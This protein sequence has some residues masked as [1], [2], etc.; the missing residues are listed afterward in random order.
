MSTIKL[1]HTADVHLDAPNGSLGPRAA[2]LRERTWSAWD[3]A[4]DQALE[5]GI[6][7][8]IVAGDL[9]DV[10][11]PA[12]RTVERALSGI[13]RLAEATPA[14]E[15]VLLPGTHDCWA[16]GALWDSPR[17]K[18]LA[19][20]VHLLRGPEAESVHIPHLDVMVHGC[21]HRCDIRGQRPVCE[22]R[23]SSE[24]TINIG[25]AH[26]SWERGDI[27]EDS[28]MYSDAE[29]A[30]TGLDY[31]ALGH[32]H[33]FFDVS[34]GGVTA[35]N[36]GSPEVPGFGNWDRGSVAVVTLG[37]GPAL[38]QRV[39]V[40]SLISETVEVDAA[41]LSGTE[42]LISRLE[43]HADRD[44]LLEVRLSG[45]AAPGVM[46]D[47]ELAMERLADA[48]FALR[49]R[50][51]SHPALDEF[52]DEALDERLTLGRFVKLARKQ[53]EAA[54]DDRERRV[55]ERA[56]QVGVSMLRRERGAK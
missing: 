54:N 44:R 33:S 45:L 30:A 16:E 3:S 10:R 13:R 28:S 2:E 4:I 55:A 38:V 52:D 9:F 29:I 34:S 24:A 50:D 43:E 22:L 1:L 20:R 27:S 48:C 53:I 32:W 18:A 56:L 36:P 6:Q 23:A 7:L 25:V 51:R 12:A 49:I 31:L 15:T 17:I 40:G 39:E 21:A 11:L 37:D 41:D 8:F 26:G 19:E 46:I 42:D 14:V 47:T 35:V 5:L